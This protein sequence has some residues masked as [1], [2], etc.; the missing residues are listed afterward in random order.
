MRSLAGEF[1]ARIGNLVSA[2]IKLRAL[3]EATLDFPDEEID[4]LE[5][6]DAF[7]RLARLRVELG[8]VQHAA[9]QG[10]ILREGARCVLIGQPNVGKSK[11]LNRLVGDRSPL[12][13]R[14]RAPRVT[15]AART[16]NRRRAGARD[17]HRCAGESRSQW[18]I[19]IERAWREIVRRRCPIVGALTRE[20]QRRS[21]N[22]CEFA[23]KGK[24]ILIFNKIDLS[25]ESRQGANWMAGGNRRSPRQ[26]L[27]GVV[28]HRILNAVAGDPP[29]KHIQARERTA[30]A[31]EADAALA[32]ATGE[33]KAIELFAEELR[34]L[35]SAG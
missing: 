21:H 23:R 30:R 27:A 3:V 1:S 7:K 25:G 6:G 19:G 20:W 16:R 35:N 14:F 22:P 33:T 4:F 13:P 34:L 17:R 11:L 26:G 24:K 28:A 15:V 31:P 2:L 8:E 32:R 29:R 18:K 10:R 12:S 9:E 5:R